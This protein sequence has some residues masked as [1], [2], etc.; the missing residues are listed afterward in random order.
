MNNI[1][2]DIKENCYFFE[3]GGNRYVFSALTGAVIELNEQIDN[4]IEKPE[5]IP[6]SELYQYLLDSELLDNILKE[7][8]NTLN[9]LQIKNLT[10]YMTDKC[11][12]NCS[13][14]YERSNESSFDGS[15][16]LDIESFKR[17]MIFF[18]DNFEYSDSIALSFFGGEPLLKYNLIEDCVHFCEELSDSYNVNFSFGMTTNGTL[19]NSEIADFLARH[20]FS[21][22]I[23]IDGDKKVHDA[24]RKFKNGKGSF[25][26]IRN[27][28][29]YLKNRIFTVARVTVHDSRYDFI[30]ACD[31]LKAL[32]INNVA[33]SLVYAGKKI[34]TQ[35]D[36]MLLEEGIRRLQDYYYND[37]NNGISFSIYNFSKI[38]SYFS[39]G[40]RH[41]SSI[42]PC[43]GGVN[44]FSFSQNGDIYLCHGFANNRDYL[45]GNINEGLNSSKRLKFLQS[46][47]ISNRRDE[48][49]KCWARHLCGG[50]CYAQAADLNKINS[51]QN[52]YCMYNKEMI[53]AG[54]KLY[55]S[56]TDK[57]RSNMRSF[58]K[59]YDSIS[60][61][62]ND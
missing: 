60:K 51:D 56:L 9:Q 44:N 42:L 32:G 18:L 7:K 33:F 3:T 19:I 43:S 54:I 37:L 35:N 46:Q 2:Q 36:Y 27:N 6:G 10:I 5:T 55:A 48:C 14:C 13:Y 50:I 29:E 11:N 28:L 24:N 20:N 25:E 45:F 34:F 52:I 40:Y 61:V 59:N 57:Q 4:L 1:K 21:I 38:I 49:G 17:N 15:N 30:A 22:V 39:I 23:S 12:L 16:E 47:L 26:L 62:I 41:M 53:K 58:L 8:A 31:A